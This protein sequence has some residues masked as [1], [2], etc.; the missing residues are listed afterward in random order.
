MSAALAEAALS[1][2]RPRAVVHKFGGSSLANAAAI[3][4]AA[5]IV[6]EEE[7]APCYVVVSAAYGVTN[8]LL[9]CLNGALEAGAWRLSLARLRRR[10]VGLIRTFLS[11]EASAGL[12]AD[13]RKDF[14][15]LSQ[16]LAAAEVL[17]TA[18]GA[19]ADAVAAHGELWSMRLFAALLRE[20]GLEA[21]TL[22]AR[23]FLRARKNG[24]GAEI[25]WPASAEAFSACNDE[26]VGGIA[27]VPG[28]VASCAERG[29][30][31]TLGRNGSDWSATI[32]AR[33]AGADTVTI[34]SDVAGVLDGDPAVVAGAATQPRLGFDAAHTLAS[35]GARILHPA[36]LAPLA[37]LD[38]R[39]HVKCTF[40]PRG[41]ATQ[42]ADEACAP[43]AM[44]SA[45]E[46]TVSVIGS[47]VETTTALNALS[48]SRIE[49]KRGEIA[50]DRLSVRVPVADVA[51][52]QRI[53]HRRLCRRQPRVDVLL[54]G[55]GHVGGA[56]LKAL[57]AG[58]DDT[59]HL[60]GAA[61][62]KRF[63]FAREG[64]APERT[65]R[66]LRAAKAASEPEA[67]GDD[68]R[69]HCEA[70]P[71]I[72][73]ATASEKIARWHSRWLAGGIHVITANKIA[74]ASGWVVPRHRKQ[75]HYGDAAT[76]GA[77]LP[78]LRE[79]RR[80]RAAGDRIECIEGVFSGSLAFVFTAMERGRDLGAALAAAA[81][82][83][84]AEPDPRSD[85]SGLDVARKLA[86]IAEAAGIAADIAPPEPIVPEKLLALDATA[87]QRELPALSLEQKRALREAGKRSATLRYVAS[88]AA[89][90]DNRIGLREVPRGSPL[91]QTCGIENIAVIHSRSYAKYPLVIRGP[92]AGPDVTARALLAD[93]AIVRERF[94]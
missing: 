90:G 22:D 5:A 39:L 30:T 27:V 38:V 15:R 44:V 36:T 37:G 42:L 35:H 40:T 91:A 4:Q 50:P 57:S 67:F 29:I 60:L 63:V 25:D 64:M 66:R 93:I 18:S 74:A 83:G 86:I 62:S 87:F 48:H 33:L 77:G 88:L 65:L 75:A 80:L 78:I 11:P 26:C 31:L 52:A 32:L 10:Q 28:F 71:I 1:A 17:R 54:I 43:I 85:L 73:D 24:D 70:T 2:A 45:H 51:R 16:L 46:D 6:A 34:W 13:L 8:D 3:R 9:A 20:R 81:R 68:L 49:V 58:D 23:S 92:G 79:L 89:N 7:T 55:V 94:G 41:E 14:H 56:F 84:Y 76:V 61:D 69:A 53:W 19:L 21:M 59:V 12:R 47:G 82:A 72:V